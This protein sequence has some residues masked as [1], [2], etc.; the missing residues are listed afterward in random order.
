MKKSQTDRPIIAAVCGKGGVGKT[1]VSALIVKT[2]IENPSNK[3]LAID[4]DPAIGLSHALGIHV[5]KTVDDIRRDLIGRLESGIQSDGSML[6]AQLDY[7]L[8]ESLEEKRNMAFLA[9][10]RPEDAGCYCRVN[11]LLKDVIK[12]TAAGFDYV[13]IDGEAGI[14]QINRRVMEMVTHLLIVTD[15]SARGRNVVGTIEQIAKKRLAYKRAGV[16]F[17]RVENEAEVKVMASEIR[18]PVIGMVPESDTI[19]TYDREGKGFFEFPDGDV[20][21]EVENAFDRLTMPQSRQVK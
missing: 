8:L 20:L 15:S 12:E 7:E 6:L 1:I 9:I 5:H 21:A 4:A 18:L 19:R 16:L 14:E 3:I 13:I 10:G 17:N 11:E 2:L